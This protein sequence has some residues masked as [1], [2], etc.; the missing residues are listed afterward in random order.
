[1]ALK[2]QKELAGLLFGCLAGNSAYLEAVRIARKHGSGRIW[3]IGSGVYKTLLNVLYGSSHAIKDWDFIVERISAPL[4]A[5]S[6]WT[7]GMTKYGNPK[8]KKDSLAV[9]LIPL[10][11]IHSIKQRGLKA[12]IAHFLSGT[13]FTIQSLAFDIAGHALLGEAGI[14]SILTRTAGIN[15]QEEYDYAISMYGDV[16]LKERYAERLGLKAV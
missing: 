2:N 11:N 13:P 16:Y 8:L 1:M 12:D 7:A 4:K 14:A 15:N 9:D 5:E 10:N 6:G 3:L